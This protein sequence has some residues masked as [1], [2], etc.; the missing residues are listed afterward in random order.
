MNADNGPSGMVAAA[1][2]GRGH[3]HLSLAIS[4]PQ[5][6]NVEHSTYVYMMEF[7]KYLLVL[8]VYFM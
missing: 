1:L 4:L 6:Q 5:S 8:Y 3:I 2:C 7:R